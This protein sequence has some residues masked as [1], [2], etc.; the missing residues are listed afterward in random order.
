MND[1]DIRAL[2]CL[3]KGLKKLRW[4]CFFLWGCTAVEHGKI[5]SPWWL[6][7]IHPVCL[8]RSNSLQNLYP[9]YIFLFWFFLKIPTPSAAVLYL[10]TMPLSCARHECLQKN[11]TSSPKWSE[12]SPLIAPY[13]LF[14]LPC[15]NLILFFH[16][17]PFCSF[18]AFSP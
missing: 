13:F 10:Q 15:N 17:F 11:S 5:T 9:R 16:S 4:C 14:H 2:F 3:S 7:L 1:T 6:S 18:F 12:I 8:R